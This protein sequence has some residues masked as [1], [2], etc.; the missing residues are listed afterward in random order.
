MAQNNSVFLQKTSNWSLG[1]PKL[2]IEVVLCDIDF[3]SFFHVVFDPHIPLIVSFVVDP[4]AKLA[5]FVSA[6]KF[7]LTGN[8]TNLYPFIQ[9]CLE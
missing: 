3:R 9:G 5:S 6:R 1:R 7:Y 4:I 8:M 2:R